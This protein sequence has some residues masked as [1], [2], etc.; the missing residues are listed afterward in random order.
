MRA[1]GLGG[2]R[3]GFGRGLFRRLG[4]ALFEFETDLAGLFVQHEEGVEGA[5]FFRNE[6]REEARFAFGA[7]FA[8][9]AMTT[10]SSMSVK[11]EL[12]RS[13][14]LGAGSRESESEVMG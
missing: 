5:A 9:M 11:A 13:G 6:F 7:D 3:F 10:R 14:E 2:G 12:L 1:D 4:F 8:M